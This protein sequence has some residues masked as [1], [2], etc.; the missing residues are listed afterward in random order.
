M[1]LERPLRNQG[2]WVFPRGNLIDTPPRPTRHQ[3]L[4]R[5]LLALSEFKHLQDGC[6]RG[7]HPERERGLR[8]RDARG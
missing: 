1:S 3:V 7:S 5:A 4:I 6:A 8:G 2:G